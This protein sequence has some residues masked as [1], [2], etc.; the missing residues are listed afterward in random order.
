MEYLAEESMARSC[1]L[2]PK[3]NTEGGVKVIDG[4]GGNSK[5]LAPLGEPLPPDTGDTR[6][7][8]SS[9]SK[10]PSF[11]SSPAASRDA[12]PE[13]G[14]GRDSEVCRDTDWLEETTGCCSSDAAWCSCA[15]F[16]PRE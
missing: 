4:R 7:L 16:D 1:Q 14:M 15:A 2:D 9:P 3:L 8:P 13:A 10:D 6:D 5:L 12:I 11:L